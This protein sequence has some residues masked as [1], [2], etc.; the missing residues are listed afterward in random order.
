MP[1]INTEFVDYLLQNVDI[2]E[3]IGNRLP[4]KKSGKNYTACCPFHNEKTPSFSVSSDK[5]LFHCFGCKESGGVIEFIKK[6]DRLDFVAA[7][8]CLAKEVGMEVEYDNKSNKTFDNSTKRYKDLMLE[9]NNF[10][11]K[12]LRID[13][14]KQIAVSYAKKRHISGVIAK[15]F[16]LGYAPNGWTNIF[17]SNKDNDKSIADLVT[18]GILIAK[19]NAVGEYYDRF[20]NRL[21]FP[22]HNVRGDIVGFGGRAL[23]EEDKPKYLNSPETP[24]FSKSKELYGL[25]HCRKYSKKIDYILVVEGYMDVIALHQNGITNAVATLGT[26]TTAQHLKSIFRF[27]STIIFCFDGDEAG[28]AAAWK[29]LKISLTSIKS[30]AI[31]KFLFL[32]DEEDPDTIIRKEGVN[33]F[34]KR[35]EDSQTLSSFLFTRIKSEVPF[36][37]IEGKTLFLEKAAELINL[38]NYENYREQLI[39]GLA[40]VLQQNLLNVKNLVNQNRKTISEKDLIR[41]ETN[42]KSQMNYI[43]VGYKKNTKNLIY[44]MIH[45]LINYPLLA[46]DDIESRIQ[47]LPNVEI[48][49]EIVNNLQLNNNLTKEEIINSYR[50]N[51]SIY[52]VL[53]E[54]QA[55]DT[56]LSENEARNEFLGALKLLERQNQKNTSKNSI[57]NATTIEAQEAIA[58]E[59]IERKKTN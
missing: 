50:K 38:A 27:T 37:T 7:V 35:I 44:L 3:I 43:K 45:H 31:I 53:Q 12:Q 9:I 34:N 21:M 15:M 49:L 11:K 47:K 48:L 28:K 1:F 10:Y 39:Q 32:P 29:A 18:L 46:N 55:T 26:A 14:N 52:A 40:D 2:V 8:E 36:D 51:E 22:I 16:E 20:R 13:K 54:I 42:F 56:I 59:I 30:G 57:K 4:L 23:S 19:D 41:K 24:L 6:F 33:K 25:Y 58:R 5:Q 17:E